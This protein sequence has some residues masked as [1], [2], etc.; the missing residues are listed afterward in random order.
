MNEY[1]VSELT[2]NIKCIL[3]TKFNSPIKIIGELSSVKNSNN[4]IYITL[5]DE[6]SS[7]SVIF[8]KHNNFTF[9]KGDQVEITCKL[10]YYTKSG[11]INLIGQNIQFVGIGKLYEE[12]QQ[13]FKNFENL[14]YFNNK[15]PLP[16]NVS[17]IGI[18]TAKD[19]AALQDILYVLNK[20]NYTGEIYIYNCY[21]QGIK[22]PS[23]IIYGIEYFETENNVDILLLTRG[24]GSFEDLIGFS[25]PKVIEKI[26]SCSCYIMSAVGHE[27]D[28]MISDYVSNYRAPTPSIAAEVISTKYNEKIVYLEEI[29]N[30]IVQNMYRDLT[31]IQEKKIY[32]NTIKEKIPN[33]TNIIKI[34]NDD[35]S[36][37][38]TECYNILKN[39][40]NT[41]DNTIMEYKYKLKN[42]EHESILNKGYILLLNENGKI[43]NSE[44]KIK[45]TQKLKMLITGKELDITIN[46][47]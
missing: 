42:N 23:S 28:N 1:T 3:E 14:G 11:Y 9:N 4:N 31:N 24:G 45:K 6:K 41:L 36:L 33:L 32:L 47:K 34:K 10:S 18:L 25:D 43:I 17:K 38:D 44:N 20:N 26:H 13:N 37:I 15:N 7:I 39:I 5:K 40:L 2:L 35:I 27:V 29:D 46:I 19:G 12:Y 8:W 21:V 16:N 22:C 30:F